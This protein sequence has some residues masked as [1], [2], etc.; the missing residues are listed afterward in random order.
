MSPLGTL[1]VS[2]LLH[3]LGLLIILLARDVV[4]L[5]SAT[6]NISSLFQ[7]FINCLLEILLTSDPR[8]DPKPV[9]TLSFCSSPSF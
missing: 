7:I 6:G 3:A 8:L 9:Y 5:S 4:S 1:S 2:M